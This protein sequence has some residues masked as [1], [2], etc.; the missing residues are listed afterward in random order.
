MD[1]LKYWFLGNLI[2]FIIN[3]FYIMLLIILY[4]LLFLLQTS[5]YYPAIIMPFIPS[6]LAGLIIK[7]KKKDLPIYY[8]GTVNLV[9]QFILALFIHIASVED[10]MEHPYPETNRPG[11]FKIFFFQYVFFQTII[12]SVLG[13]VIVEIYRFFKNKNK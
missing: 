1:N 13:G 3:I 7:I 6:F 11:S 2:S 8:Y 9:I 5:D 4:P 10:F 12:A